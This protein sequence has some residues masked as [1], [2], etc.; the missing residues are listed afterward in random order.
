MAYS[1]LAYTF[2][3]AIKTYGKRTHVI[4]T[5]SIHCMAG[6]MSAKSCGE[7]FAGGQ[8]SGSSNYGIGPD[9]QIACYLD[10]DYASICTCS[11]ANDNRAVTIEVADDGS[12]NHVV[13]DAAYNSLILLLIDICRRN[14]IKQLLWRGD[15][16]LIGQV[17]KQNMTVHR[18][19]SSKECPGNYL[20]NKHAEIASTVNAKLSGNSAYTTVT[21]RTRSSSNLYQQDY[22]LATSP[23]NSS[24]IDYTNRLISTDFKER[25]SKITCIT[26]HIAFQDG[27]LGTL[28]SLLNSNSKS[29]NYGIDNDG[30]IGLFVDENMMT[31]STGD[32]YND[33]RSVNIICMNKTL[34]PDY[35]I[36]DSCYNSLIE[37]C[38]D[39]C[40]RN[41]ISYLSYTGDAL[42]DSLTM[43]SQFDS[44]VNCPGPYLTKKYKDIADKVNSRLS[45]YEGHNYSVDGYT[46]DEDALEYLREFGMVSI[47]NT[48]PYVIRIDQGVTGINYDALKNIGVVGAMIDAGQLYDSMHQQVKYR[49][50]KVYKQT[51]E[52][53]AAGLP[54]AYYYT[55]RARTLLEV[56]EEA[57]WFYFVVSKYPPKLGVWLH[58]SFNISKETAPKLVNRWY[59]YFVDWGLKSKCGLY[60]SEKQADLIGW[61]AQCT[62]MNLWLES[63]PSADNCPDEEILVPSFFQKISEYM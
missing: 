17:D 16:N 31:P 41:S 44:T 25:N 55:T 19:F 13:S 1:G 63:G 48:R 20:Y 30:K 37:L 15:R 40:R 49:T 54:H 38:E 5:I 3:K 10:E 56:K 9:G 22:K 53:L 45:S 4:D 33:N 50:D 47:Q 8:A 27:S 7:W 61:P 60:C 29:Y 26:I 58:C 35:S 23:L 2:I 18:W 34:S 39:V 28:A 12:A 46:A 24:I 32:D 52:V 57:Y 59:E 14:N 42:K 51:Q 21:Y 36:S 11:K 62:Y 6:P 43:H